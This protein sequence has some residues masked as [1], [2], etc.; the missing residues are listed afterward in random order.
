VLVDQRRAEL[1]GVDRAGDGLDGRHGG[2]PSLRAVP[3]SW[4]ITV[5]ILI[6]C[7]AASMVIA[8]T[9]LL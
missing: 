5:A 6:I 4:T 3:R 7:L 1:V 2:R 9:K 8:L